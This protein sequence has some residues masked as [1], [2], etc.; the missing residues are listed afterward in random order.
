[1]LIIFILNAEKNSPPNPWG[2]LLSL[3]KNW[4]RGDIPIATSKLLAISEMVTILL[5]HE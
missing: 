5:M 1:M 4:C 2:I 3:C